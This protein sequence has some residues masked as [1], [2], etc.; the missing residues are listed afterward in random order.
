MRGKFES[1][2]HSLVCGNMRE[3]ADWCCMQNTHKFLHRLAKI[4]LGGIKTCIFNQRDWRLE[5]WS[6]TA[7]RLACWRRVTWQVWFCT[8]W[9]GRTARLFRTVP[10]A[11]KELPTAANWWNFQL[12]LYSKCTQPSVMSMAWY[13]LVD[14]C[15]L[16]VRN[17]R[18]SRQ[19]KRLRG[20]GCQLLWLTPGTRV[21][22]LS[23]FLQMSKNLHPVQ[24]LTVCR[25]S[26]IHLF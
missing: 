24:L 14:P 1:R 11:L 25:S 21:T 15:L 9:T 22:Y 26:Q 17:N 18:N 5:C 3:F 13:T 19:R 7:A 23:H 6:N 2:G 4:Q 10:V 12:L 20:G 16:P 8:W